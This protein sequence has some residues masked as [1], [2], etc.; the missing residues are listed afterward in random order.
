MLGNGDYQLVEVSPGSAT[1]LAQTNS[2]LAAIDGYQPNIKTLNSGAALLI[3]DALALN[4][5][6]ELV[7]A[8]SNAA[9]Y[10]FNCVGIALNAAGA[11]GVPVRFQLIGVVAFTHAF[12]PGA[13][14][15]LSDTPG[16]ITNVA[17]AAARIIGIA[18]AGNKIYIN[19][20]S[21]WRAV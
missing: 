9:A 3:K 2:D 11:P 18:L 4:G 13:P 19:A 17:P 10:L 20:P 8:D 12:T 1:I 16:V 6:G 15:Y 5:S 14:I 7:K 21:S